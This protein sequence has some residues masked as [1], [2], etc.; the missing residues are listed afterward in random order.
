MTLWTADGDRQQISEWSAP[1]D[2][3]DLKTDAAGT[4]PE[5]QTL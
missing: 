1:V 5:Q 3:L 4:W 2:G